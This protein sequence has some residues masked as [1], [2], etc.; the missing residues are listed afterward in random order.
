[1]RFV[2]SFLVFIAVVYTTTAQDVKVTL[3]TVFTRRVNDTL[4]LLVHQVKYENGA[5]RENADVIQ[6]TT[7]FV[8]QTRKGA[9]NTMIE[10]AGT[11]QNYLDKRDAA[12]LTLRAVNQLLV[13]AT[14]KNYYEWAADQFADSTS[15]IGAWRLVR[16]GIRSQFHIRKT[17]QGA[18]QAAT[19]ANFAT[20]TRLPIRV[21]CY[22]GTVGQFEVQF[23][24]GVWTRL[25][26][27][28][29]YQSGIFVS[30]WTD[31]N[32]TKLFKLR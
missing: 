21:L 19:N 14:G 11:T 8:D 17:V 24:T 2:L 16:N 13:S 30:Q 15:V 7:V 3:D 20:N 10:L 9:A 22:N 18:L 28:G 29:T 27:R 12:Q 4:L 32:G 1:M 26:Y 31:E 23:T 5:T 6:D 25:T